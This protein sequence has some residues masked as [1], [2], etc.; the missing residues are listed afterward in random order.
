MRKPVVT[1]TLKSTE[2]NVLCLDIET[3]EP[4]NRTIIL[5]RT[6]KNDE[7]MLKVAKAEIDTDK[8]KAVAIA[9]SKVKLCK[10]GMSEAAFIA[11]AEFTE[12]VAE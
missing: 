7:A 10:Y 6:Y 5:P 8:V 11:N 12:E 3:A 2:V 9:A 4:F 1:R